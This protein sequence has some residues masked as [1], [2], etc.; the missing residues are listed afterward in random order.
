MITLT[1]VSILV[2]ESFFA[3]GFM[4]FGLAPIAARYPQYRLLLSPVTWIFWRIPTHAEW[5]ITRLQTEAMQQLE[6]M[7]EQ[8]Q[9]T[10]T[11]CSQDSQTQQPPVQ[12]KD[13]CTSPVRVG[14][15]HCIS[16]KRHGN[17]CLSTEKVSF[18]NHLTST[19]R[20]SLNYEDLKSIEKAAGTSIISSGN[21]LLFRDM[22][23]KEYV[24]SKLKH[25]D[26]VFS[27]IIGYSNVRWQRMI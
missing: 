15:Y 17:L 20:W 19:E 2:K 24:A 25:R 5:A 27:Q 16:E 10:E 21:A 3:M 4:F 11:S 6:T 9:Y 8:I 14:R 23:G 7:R 18:E 22:D 1:P 12:I 26:E 13:D